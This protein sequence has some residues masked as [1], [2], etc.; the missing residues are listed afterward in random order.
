MSL[1]SVTLQLEWPALE[2][3]ELETIAAGELVLRAYE[4]RNR[5]RKLNVSKA[6]LDAADALLWKRITALCEVQCWEVV[7]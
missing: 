7:A 2:C 4:L 5:I 1:Q 6:C 3:L